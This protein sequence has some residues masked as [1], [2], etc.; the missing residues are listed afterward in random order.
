MMYFL[1]EQSVL[2]GKDSQHDVVN[3]IVFVR[4]S[5]RWC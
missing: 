5:C 4:S 3:D 2:S 1:A